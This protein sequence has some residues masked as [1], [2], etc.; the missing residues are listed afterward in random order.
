M[1]TALR[2]HLRLFLE[3]VEIPVIS[4][5]VQTQKNAA[6]MASIAIPFNDEALDLRPRTLVHLFFYDHFQGAPSDEL[7]AIRGEGISVQQ[8]EDPDV[9][10]GF[11]PEQEDREA[12]ADSESDIENSNYRLLFGGEVV[13][14][15]Y[16]K[17][18]QSRMFVL[19]CVDW[20]SYW[21][22]A[23]QYQISGYSLGRGGIRAAFSGA[24]TTVFNSFL[25]GSADIITQLLAAPPRNYPELRNTLLGGLMHVIEAIGGVYFGNRAIRGVNDFFSLAELRLHITQMI[26]ANPYQQRDELRLLRARGFGS[27]W[28]RRLSGLGKQVSIRQVLL[29]LQPYIFHEILPIT[30]PRYVPPAFDPAAPNIDNVRLSDDRETEPLHRAADRLHSALEDIEGR[31]AASTD[32][33]EASRQSELRGGLVS[34]LNQLIR[35]C[36]QAANRAQRVGRRPG[37]G[38]M[39]EIRQVV[40]LFTTVGSTLENIKNLVATYSIADSI[41]SATQGGSRLRGSRLPVAGTQEANRILRATSGARDGLRQ[42]MEGQYQRQGARRA[43]PPPRLMNQLYVPDVWMVAPP[44]CNV[45]F[46]ELYSDLSYSR[47]FNQ[48]VSR[49]LLRTHSAFFGSDYFFDGFYIAPSKAVGARTNRSIARGRVGAERPMDDMDLPAYVARDLMDHEL[50]TGIIPHFERMSDLNLHALRGGSFTINGQRVGFAQ[51]ACNHIFFQYRFR[52]RN[53]AVSGKFNPYLAF[54]FPVAVIDRYRTEDMD[55]ADLPHDQLVSRMLLEAQRDGEGVD[56]GPPEDR[57]RRQELA[58]IRESELNDALLISRKN[59]HYLGTPQAMT[60]M[61]SAEQGGHTQIQMGYARTTNERAE[62]LGEDF[63]ATRR[64]RRVRNVRRT[65]YVAALERP[66]VGTVGPHGGNVL[67]VEQVTDQYR[68]RQTLSRGQAIRR[69]QA[70]A[71]VT[72]QRLSRTPRAVL[73]LFVPGSRA[74]GRRLRQTVVEVGVER[75]VNQYPPEI[76]ALV[77]SGGE[78]QPMVPGGP[79]VTVTFQAYRIVE[80]LGAYQQVNVPLPPED[81]V[82]PPWYGE[83]YRTQNIGGLYSYFFGVGALTDPTTILGA[84]NTTGARVERTDGPNVDDSGGNTLSTSE[85]RRLN[86]A[87]SRRLDGGDL[88][89]IVDPWEADGNDPQ[90]QVR[91]DEELGPPGEVGEEDTLSTVRARSPIGEALDEIVKAYALIKMRNYDVHQFLKAYSWRPI[92]SMLDILG[93]ADLQISD[94][95]VVQRGY[96]GFHSRAF[97]DY[98][99]LRTLVGPSNGSRPRRILGLDT[100]Q[101]EADL[102]MA[103]TAARL[104]TRKEKRQQVLRY[105]HRLLA[106]HGMVG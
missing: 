46:P 57:A 18:P 41:R 89:D 106:G 49:L 86:I 87:V 98:D 53:L 33:E 2:L 84:N 9:G 70:G 26:G 102:T 34:E 45:I 42:I 81:L 71:P 25:D 82:F 4:A 96:E 66:E 10:S 77:G 80:E 62:F 61:V 76:A 79:T 73:P 52:S 55:A 32:R 17:N 20:S 36:R 28:R 50:F 90:D 6:A 29:A 40:A 103:E 67:S 16:S 94:D 37:P 100:D 19:Q 43:G 104:D 47:N 72:D 38:K 44:R 27:L 11:P 97:G 105:L 68:S 65:T 78:T 85:E 7:L 51:F 59:T 88:S 14:F 21:D 13:G 1:T 23:F 64:R 56:D 30:T 35:V 8:E 74:T 93:S 83:H 24:A 92:A 69:G 48:E 54:G 39:M 58:R 99:D 12:Y 3:G 5:H 31:I 22:I 15:S 95:G 91:D 60:H 75:P 63:R 101:S